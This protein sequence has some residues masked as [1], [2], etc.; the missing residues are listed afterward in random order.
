MSDHFDALE[1]RDPEQ[2]EAALM[3][4]L[5]AQ[6]AH[7][8]ANAPA[9]AERFAG[10]GGGGQHPRRARRACRCC[11]RASC[12]S[13]SGRRCASDAVRR[14]RRDRLGRRRPPARRATH[15]FVSP[16]PDLR[17]RERAARLLAHG[18]R[19][20]RRRLSRRRPGAQQLQ[21]SLHAR[22]RDD[23]QRRAWRSAAR[24]FPAGT[25]Q[26]EL[27][28][29][30]M[31]DLRPDAYVG[32]PSFL[33]ILLEKADETGVALPSLK[34]ASRRRRGVSRRRCA[35]GSRRAA[36]PATRA[37]APPTSAWSPTRPRRARAWSSTRA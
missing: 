1:T 23:G 31:A 33:R 27:Q 22:R 32:T 19:P 9:G 36:S 35:T 28:L 37:T 15:V 16:G 12:S 10:V 25:G 5:A 20:V 7:A 14:L 21:L 3:A 2:R 13:G 34:K 4:A 18:P 8:R 29:Q 24:C 30:A 11:A 6:V 17:A 26:T